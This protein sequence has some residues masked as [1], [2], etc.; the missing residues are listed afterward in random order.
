MCTSMYLIRMCIAISN[1]KCVPDE[2]RSVMAP[3]SVVAPFDSAVLELVCTLSFR[4]V[5]H[6]LLTLFLGALPL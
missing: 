1:N 3:P 5:A 6:L 4:Q 2:K